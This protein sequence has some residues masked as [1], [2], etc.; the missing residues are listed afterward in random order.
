MS[1]YD[2]VV[3]TTDRVHISTGISGTTEASFGDELTEAEIEEIDRLRLIRTILAVIFIGSY[4]CITTTCSAVAMVI[5]F[6]KAFMRN[7]FAIGQRLLAILDIVLAAAVLLKYSAKGDAD[8]DVTYL[9]KMVCR[10]YKTFYY[11]IVANVNWCI[12][13]LSVVRFIS[14]KYPLKVNTH[15]FVRRAYLS[16]ICTSSFVSTFYLLV[17]HEL[18]RVLDVNKHQPNPGECF[19]Y[20]DFPLNEYLFRTAIMTVKTL[21]PAIV[22]GVVNT[23][24][25]RE[26]RNVSIKRGQL[27]D[28]VLL[29]TR[30]IS[31][32]KFVVAENERG[33]R[34]SIAYPRPPKKS[35]PGTRSPADRKQTVDWKLAAQPMNRVS[36]EVQVIENLNPEVKWPSFSESGS[37]QDKGSHKDQI[38]TFRHTLRRNTVA[39]GLLCDSE[40]TP[41]LSQQSRRT[42]SKTNPDRQ[43]KHV[44]S[45]TLRGSPSDPKTRKIHFY[46]TMKLTNINCLII[47]TTAVFFIQNTPYCIWYI[48]GFSDTA[49]NV[50]IDEILLIL[51]CFC[52]VFDVPLYIF[53]SNK[54]QTEGGKLLTQFRRHI[55]ENRHA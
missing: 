49:I 11:T 54:V 32:M 16:L 25:Y 13:Y 40:N 10:V 45:N 4:F 2:D 1:T 38:K 41:I 14:L 29:H 18:T 47:L 22:I 37:Y 5:L 34:K 17:Y 21:V 8:L 48:C 30:T 26:F 43:Q 6:Q 36:Y 3:N 24:T 42:S 7:A 46:D 44:R 12:V 28:A 23:L 19:S 31:E 9:N 53:T 51:Q 20:A 50:F 39:Y 52:H 15:S 35:T 27:K 55:L 33:T